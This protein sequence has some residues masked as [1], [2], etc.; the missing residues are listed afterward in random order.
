MSN[1]LTRSQLPGEVALA[2]GISVD[3]VARYAR[4][5][6]IPF[7]KTPKGHR[8]YNL[9]EVRDALAS[10]QRSGPPLLAAGSS[11]QRRPLVTG[12]AV[13]ASPQSRLREE[14]RATRTADGSQEPT[15]DPAP[16]GGTAFDQ[17]LVHAKRVLVA[18]G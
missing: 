15:E 18:E 7:A 8:R 16:R 13:K 3:T 14:L 2:L 12:P 11:T 4:E 10:W 9:A 17:V 5:G 6:L 1:T